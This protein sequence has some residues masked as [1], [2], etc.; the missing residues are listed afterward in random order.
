MKFGQ[1]VTFRP[2]NFFWADF[3]GKR[4]QKCGFFSFF[5]KTAQKLK[6]SKIP[7]EV[8]FLALKGTIWPNFMTNGQNGKKK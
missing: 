3:G 4:G 5:A 7:K 2:R 1:V 6:F 8:L